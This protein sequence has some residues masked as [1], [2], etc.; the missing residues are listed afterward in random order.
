MAVKETKDALRGLIAFGVAARAVGKD[1]WTISDAGLLIRDDKLQTAAADAL[2]GSEKIPY[3]LSHLS[4]AD[5]IDLVQT[6][7]EAAKLFEPKSTTP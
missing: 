4:F 1:G 2:E 7:A 6:L 5:T 3:E